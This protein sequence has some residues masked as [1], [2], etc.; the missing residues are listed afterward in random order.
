MLIFMTTGLLHDPVCHAGD[1]KGVRS[2]PRPLPAGP[3]GADDHT[4]DE[5]T[6]NEKWF[7]ILKAGVLL[8]ARD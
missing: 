7:V 6:G 4:P 2:W 1:W 5:E 3:D 8:F